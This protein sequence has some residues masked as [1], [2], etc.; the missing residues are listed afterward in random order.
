MLWG[1]SITEHAFNMRMAQKIG[2]K[3]DFMQRTYWQLFRIFLRLPTKGG[4]P[5]LTAS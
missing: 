2:K 3:T 1:F 4:Y 5:L